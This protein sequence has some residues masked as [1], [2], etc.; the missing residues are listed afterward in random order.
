MVF[1][2][3]G[4]VL[5]Y[6]FWISIILSVILLPVYFFGGKQIGILEAK[7]DLWRGR[8]EIHGYGLILWEP[9]EIQILKGYGIEY[10]HVAGCVVDGFIIDSVAAYNSTMK[11]AIKEDKGVDVDK[12][13]GRSKNESDAKPEAP[14]VL[15]E[16]LK[17]WDLENNV[18]NIGDCFQTLNVDVDGDEIKEKICLRC[19]QYKEYD[20]VYT[21]VS[22]VL[23]MFKGKKQVLRQELDRG[24]FFEER[25]VSLKDI[26]SDGKTE[27]IT[28]VRFSPDCSGCSSYRIYTFNED[29]FELALNLFNIKPNNFSLKNVLGKLSGFEEIILNEYRKRTKTEHPCNIYEGCQRSDPWMVD[30]DHDDQPEV[31]LLV[32]TPEDTDSD[33]DKYYNL[34]LAKFTKSGK[35]AGYNLHKI[36][37]EYCDAFV[38]VLGFLGTQDKHTHLL[39][40]FAYPGTSTGYPLLNIFDVQPTN[41]HKVGE[42]AGFYEHVIAERLKDIDGNGN[43]DIIYI[44]YTYWPPG[45]SHA[46]I[47]P[48]YG[49]AEYRDGRYVEANEKFK[50]ILERLND[51]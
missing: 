28:R 17:L 13:L 40:N 51:Q 16:T 48:I 20:D 26:D 46:F 39:I 32:R 43:T 44:E 3:I 21:Y 50:K 47:V 25:F 22:L 33:T 18:Y 12:L 27:L 38:D 10:R 49:I 37:L 14:L 7:Y 30:L 6:L 2:L 35:L 9:P 11:R 41:I 5:R 8:Y 31:V 42:F 23:D 29:R 34:F 45:K 15:M 19:L 24:F 4:K 36:D 1:R